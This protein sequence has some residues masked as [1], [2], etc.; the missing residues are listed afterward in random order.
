MTMDDDEFD[1]FFKLLAALGMIL[2]LSLSL[3]ILAV[4][5]RILNG[6]PILA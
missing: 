6:L 4:A 2:T 3:L 1:W 5:W